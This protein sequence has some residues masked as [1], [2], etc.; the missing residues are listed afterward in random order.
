MNRAGRSRAK[1][2]GPRFG[3]GGARGGAG[4]GGSGMDLGFGRIEDW[5]G[6]S[7]SRP[8]GC[9]ACCRLE[10]CHFLYL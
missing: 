8:I 1:R 9:F 7:G 3:A 6:Y 10:L 2:D 4:G 5:S